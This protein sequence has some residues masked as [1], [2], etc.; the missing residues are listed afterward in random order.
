VDVRVHGKN[1]RISD[2]LQELA[3]R[4]VSHAARIF[5]RRDAT[6]D[7]E[8]S[9]YANPRV[10]EDR[11]R[12]EVTSGI[13]GRVVR[14]EAN[15]ADARSAVDMATDK[16]ERRLRDL[17][18]RLIDRS[19]RAHKDLNAGVGNTEESPDGPAITRIKRFAMKPMMPEEAALQMEM[20][21]HSFFLFLNGRT[22][23]YAVVYERRDGSLG[24]LEHE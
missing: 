20:L 4:K 17:K 12:A 19:R 9:A 1:L 15:A 22:D 23:R 10:R 5:D 24:L 6:A 3:T 2:E 7:V 18:Q 21:G 16:F 13:G 14:V 11:F 8:V